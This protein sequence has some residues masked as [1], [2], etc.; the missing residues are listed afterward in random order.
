MAEDKPK[1]PAHEIFSIKC[2]WF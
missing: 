1:Q 2:R